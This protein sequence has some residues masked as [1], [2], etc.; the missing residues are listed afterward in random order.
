MLSDILEENAKLEQKELKTTNIAILIDNAEDIA[1]AQIKEIAEK[2]KNLKI[3]TK[4][5]SK[6]SY[7]EEELYIQYGIAMQITNNR[8][9]ALLNTDI[10]INF[11]FNENRINEYEIPKLATIINIQS[12]VKIKKDN[13]NGKVINNYIIDYDKKLV[14][15]FEEKQDFDSNVLYE[16]LIYRKDTYA[17]IKSQLI[18]D[19]VTILL[20]PLTKT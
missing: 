13:F 16:S 17:N 3:I 5:I 19:N 2:V 11:D 18:K 15:E 12:V 14:E 1:L 20:N 7:L 6:F 9:K 8:A 10:I 4:N